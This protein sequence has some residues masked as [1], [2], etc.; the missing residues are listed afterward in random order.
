MQLKLKPSWVAVG[1][2]FAL[3]CRVPA[4]APLESLTLT[5]MHGREPLHS[6]TFSEAAPGPQEAT[7]TH[8]A[9]AR[10]E[11]SHHN[12]S[13]LA[14]LDLRPVGG[15]IIRGVSEPQVLK[16]YGEGSPAWGGRGPLFASPWG[17]HSAQRDPSSA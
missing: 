14:E 2:P 16:V 11:D 13:C 6:Q 8:S 4:V 7:A 10:S 3:E 9:T 1:R 12:F 17:S 15:S 5:L